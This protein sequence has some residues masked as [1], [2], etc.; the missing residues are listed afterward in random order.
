M[1]PSNQHLD[2]DSR[3]PCCRI[4]FKSRNGRYLLM[5]YG[6]EPARHRLSGQGT[7][8]PKAFA[9]AQIRQ[10]LLRVAEPDSERRRWA[11][12]PRPDRVGLSY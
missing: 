1:R 4:S 7:Q 10:T 3:G 12:N 11:W 2:W 5:N 6:T 9:I 8:E